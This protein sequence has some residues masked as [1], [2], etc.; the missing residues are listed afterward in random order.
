MIVGFFVWR[1]GGEVVYFSYTRVATDFG[2]MVR[3]LC[4]PATEE[5]PDASKVIFNATHYE[6]LKAG[7][8]QA[9]DEWLSDAERA[10]LLNGTRYII[11]E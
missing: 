5:Q 10:S 8:I 7:F 11:F 6:R 4:N 9:T 1:L 3:T 2:D